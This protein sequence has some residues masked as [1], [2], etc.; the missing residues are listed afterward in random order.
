MT[1]A[2]CLSLLNSVKLMAISK[3]LLSKA[4]NVSAERDII[5]KLSALLASTY[6][7]YSALELA[8]RLAISKKDCEDAAFFYKSSI[9][10]KMEA[11]RKCVDSMEVLTAREYWPVPTYGDITFRV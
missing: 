1:Q 11:L 8:E 4:I 10:P 3:C 2:Q 6:E 5:E 7:A 9:I